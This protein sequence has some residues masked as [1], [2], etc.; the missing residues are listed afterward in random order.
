M[1]TMY[2]CIRW[3]CTYV[4]Y[5]HM[6]TTP[7]KMISVSNA[8]KTTQVVESDW[9]KCSPKY[10]SEIPSPATNSYDKLNGDL[11]GSRGRNV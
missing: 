9:K 7:M 10:P 6:Y 1:Y 5:V 2:I 4:Y 3:L 8:K 11:S